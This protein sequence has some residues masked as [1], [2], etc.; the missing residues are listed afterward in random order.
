MEIVRVS[1]SFTVKP[2]ST[3]NIRVALHAAD[4]VHGSFKIFRTY[5]FGDKES[6][7]K[8]VDTTGT[9]QPQPVLVDLGTV[10]DFGSFDFTAGKTGDY[11]LVF[12]N[13][14]GSSDSK[15]QKEIQLSYDITE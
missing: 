9:A 10:V 3:S 8:V 14:L 11:L 5:G 12:D 4:K 6:N 1:Q 7:F 15:S 13:N 2:R